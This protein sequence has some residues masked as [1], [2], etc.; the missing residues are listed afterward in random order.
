MGKRGGKVI[1]AERQKKVIRLEDRGRERKLVG[2]AWTFGILAVL[3]VAYCVGIGLFIG[4]GTY[5]FLIWG[6]MGAVFG[7]ISLLCAKPALRRRIPLS[8][9]RL[10]WTCFGIGLAILLAVEGMILSRCQARGAGAADYVIVLGAQWKT[11]GPSKVLQYRL[12][13]TLE[14]LQWNPDTM[15]IVSGGQGPGEPIAEAEGMASYLI[16]AGIAPERILQENTSQ[17]TYENLKNSALF[18]DKKEDTVVIVTNNFHVFRAERL[19]RGLGYAKATGQA[20]DSYPPMQ[21]HNLFREFF[22]VVKDFFM[23]NMIYW[24]RSE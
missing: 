13:E 16:R 11:S 1:P 5:F 9:M 21:I 8:L 20:A 6:V 10:F 24:E 7:L 19:A 12:D 23:G 22:G 15:V 4:Y 17:N 2:A 3:C 18:L 14:Y